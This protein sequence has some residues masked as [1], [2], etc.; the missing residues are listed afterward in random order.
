MEAVL[1]VTPTGKQASFYQP[2]TLSERLVQ[3]MTSLGATVL[4]SKSSALAA[5][6]L[7][8]PIWSPWIRAGLRNMEVY[9]QSVKCLGL[10]RAQV[11]E[12]RVTGGPASH[13]TRPWSFRLPGGVAGPPGPTVRLLLGDPWPGGARVQ[14]DFPY[15]PKVDLLAPG[16]LV[17][18]L[19][20]AEDERFRLFKVIREVYSPGLGLWLAEYPF[21]D[22]SA[23][24]DVSLQ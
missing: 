11:L 6:A 18:A 19:V 17:E 22:R 9:L 1:P 14:L 3:M 21:V 10:W 15:Q 7:L 13:R 8:F 12:V 2:R 20:L 5:P 24:L 23:F 16:E 4:L